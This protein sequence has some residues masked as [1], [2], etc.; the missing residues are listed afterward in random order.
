MHR[1][2][3]AVLSANEL[4][5]LTPEQRAFYIARRDELQ[6]MLDVIVADGIQSGDFLASYPA[7]ASRAITSLCLGVAVWYVAQGELPEDEFLVRYQD[8][9]RS[10]VVTRSSIERR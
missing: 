9:A 1:Q 3:G 5:N 6:R 10:I 2:R 4:P 7:D 8:I